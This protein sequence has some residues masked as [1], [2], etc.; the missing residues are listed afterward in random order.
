L[1][2]KAEGKTSAEERSSQDSDEMEEIIELAGAASADDKDRQSMG[3]SE[4]VEDEEVIELTDEL[5]EPGLEPQ[6]PVDVSA[7][8]ED[9]A[10][11]SAVHEAVSEE[12]IEAIIR[13]VVEETIEKKADR[14]LLE[15]AEAAVTKE[16]EKIKQVL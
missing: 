5:G 4:V 7:M 16:I 14:I 10:L 2:A 15:V 6:E 9:K 12:R 8:V 11:E 3:S 1:T 13:R